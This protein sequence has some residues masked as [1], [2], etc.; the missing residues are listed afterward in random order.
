LT[1]L[2]EQEE[3]MNN[4]KEARH[5][6]HNKSRP[7]DMHSWVEVVVVPRIKGEVRIHAFYETLF[8]V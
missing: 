1:H 5:N 8:V 4:T 2:E 7:Y 3:E 6:T